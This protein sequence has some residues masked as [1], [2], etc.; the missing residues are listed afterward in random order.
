MLFFT[1]DFQAAFLVPIMHHLIENPSEVVGGECAQPE[2]II[3]A[4]TRELVIQIF[5]VARK[6]AYGTV[7]KICMHYGG[8]SSRHFNQLLEVSYSYFLLPKQD[9]S[10]AMARSEVWVAGFRAQ[11]MEGNIPVEIEACT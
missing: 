9:H 5:D 10:S 4:P 1:V 6:Y 3:C 8:A 11:R 2:V 7:L